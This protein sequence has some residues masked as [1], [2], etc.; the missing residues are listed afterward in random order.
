MYGARRL[1]DLVNSTHKFSL[2]VVHT[3]KLFNAFLLMVSLLNVK[4]KQSLSPFSTHLASGWTV[5]VKTEI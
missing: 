4:K 1:Q 5:H 2:I 3:P